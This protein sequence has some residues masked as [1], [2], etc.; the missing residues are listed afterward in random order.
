MTDSITEHE[1][2]NTHE[3]VKR[4]KEYKKLKVRKINLDISIYQS[5]KY[6]L[7]YHIPCEYANASKAQKRKPTKNRMI[8]S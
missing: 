6:L 4:K 8:F 3:C 5:V 2:K 7:L 1:T